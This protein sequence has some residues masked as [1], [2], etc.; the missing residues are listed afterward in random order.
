LERKT[1]SGIMLTLLLI[2]MLTLTFNIQPVKA[3]G[4]NYIRPDGSVEGTDKI[5]QDGHLY[6]FT[7]NIYD[8]I[9]VERNNIAVDENEYTLQGSGYG[10]HL[11]GISNVTIQNTNIKNFMDGVFLHESHA[12]I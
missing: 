12:C 7:D 1:V 8:S 6:T 9:F 3:G 11:S 2:G 10:F 5:E 4:T